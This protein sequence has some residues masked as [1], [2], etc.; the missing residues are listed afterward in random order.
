MQVPERTAVIIANPEARRAIHADAL[1]AAALAM[2]ARGWRVGIEV[3]TTALDARGRAERH[4]RD[5]VDALIACGG[6]GTLL[7]VLNGLRDAGDEA[8]TAVGLIP[9]GT[10]NVWA[11]EAGIPRDPVRAL[12]LLEEGAR[13]RVDLGV[14]RI[15]E[16]APVRFLL[17]CGVGLDAAV[18][19]SVERRPHW[20]RRLGRLAFGPSSLVTIAGWP[21]A[22]A[23]VAFED[24]TDASH[25]APELLLT[26]ATN[27][28]RYG[29]VT[30]LARRTA[31]DDGLLEFT[32]FEA[33]SL[34]AR[35][36]LAFEAWR[37]RL[38]ERDVTGVRHRQAA[39]VTITPS[40]PLPVQL[41][42][43][44]VGRCG[45]TAPLRIEVEHRVVTMILGVR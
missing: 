32:T 23:H 29:G 38:D 33:G 2:R 39:R 5:G 9:A 12:A 13:Q 17:S 31:F 6:D 11:A 21:S 15:G 28:A 44:S 45:P 26:L 8:T 27:T 16:G 18:V 41:D 14:A 24:A 34:V 20:K 30:T 35:M 25:H 22:A 3:A 19:E 37:G 4:T 42:G 40:R 7:A 10:A 1:E 36:A 43:E